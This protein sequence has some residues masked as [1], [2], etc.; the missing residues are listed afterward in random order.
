MLYG[1]SNAVWLWQTGQDTVNG[2]CVRG[3]SLLTAVIVILVPHWHDI[4]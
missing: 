1:A 2:V 4:V 3:A